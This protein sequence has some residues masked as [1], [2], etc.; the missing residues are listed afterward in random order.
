[1]SMSSVSKINICLSYSILFSTKASNWQPSKMFMNAEEQTCD[2]YFVKVMLYNP[3]HM[4]KTQM[5]VVL[6]IVLIIGF[7]QLIWEQNWGN[8]YRLPINSCCLPLGLINSSIMGQ[9]SFSYMPHSMPHLVIQFQKIYL[10][11]NT[12]PS[13]ICHDVAPI[14]F[15]AVISIPQ[16]V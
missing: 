9:Y 15:Y 11:V 16:T 7:D 2:Y 13:G 1:M 14:T 3:F 12:I 6:I 8:L 5:T 10:N 4:F